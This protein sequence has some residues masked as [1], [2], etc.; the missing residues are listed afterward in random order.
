[1]GTKKRSKSEE[2]PQHPELKRQQ[3]PE[4]EEKNEQT[5]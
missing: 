2:L 3:P 4:E 5:N 1:M